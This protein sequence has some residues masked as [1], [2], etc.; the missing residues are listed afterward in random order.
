[1]K[2]DQIQKIQC[3]QRSMEEECEIIQATL[4]VYRRWG[5][6]QGKAEQKGYKQDVSISSVDLELYQAYCKVWKLACSKNRPL[7]STIKGERMKWH[8]KKGLWSC[9]RSKVAG[10]AA[11][12]PVLWRGECQIKGKSQTQSS[13]PKGKREHVYMETEISC[14]MRS[15]TTHFEWQRAI[16]K[17]EDWS[18]SL[19]KAGPV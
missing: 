18:Q 10:W 19:S 4:Q 11:S 15:V 3:R 9:H 13:M 6:G 2:H 12:N 1:M 17:L 14:L 7:R 8:C 5:G 16:S